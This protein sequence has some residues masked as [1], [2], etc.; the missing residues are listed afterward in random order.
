MTRHLKCDYSVTPGKFLGQILNAC[1][2]G[3][4]PLMCCFCLKIHDVCE[5][6][7]TPNFL[8]WNFS[9]THRYFLCDVAFRTIIAKFSEKVEV[10]LSKIYV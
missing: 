9:I 1:L 2:A 10:Q 3:F 4:C 5:I 6:S 7:I 8:I